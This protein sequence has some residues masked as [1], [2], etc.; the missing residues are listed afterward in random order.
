MGTF[1]LVP[2][3]PYGGAVKPPSTSDEGGDPSAWRIRSLTHWSVGLNADLVRNYN[4]RYPVFRYHN[5]Q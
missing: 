1:N 2:W 3:Y 5:F 4:H